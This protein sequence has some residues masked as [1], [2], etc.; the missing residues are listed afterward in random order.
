MIDNLPGR[1]TAL[2]PARRVIGTLLVLTVAA[3]SLACSGPDSV[4]NVDITLH[5]WGI[6]PAAIEVEADTIAFNVNNDGPD[7]SHE[8]VVIRI[9]N[10][11]IAGIP[12]VDGMIPEDEVDF[13]DELEEIGVGESGTLE[14]DLSAG[15]YLLLCNIVEEEDDGTESHFELGMRALLIVN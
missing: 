3:I 8:F 1:I 12:V 6:S 9:G 5:E 13:V 14:V 11:S 2:Q 4:T 15:R 7:D 10:T